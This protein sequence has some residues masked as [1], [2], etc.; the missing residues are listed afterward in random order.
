MILL[1]NMFEFME[2]TANKTLLINLL[3][4]YNILRSLIN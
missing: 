1:F 4:K 3:Y 2:I